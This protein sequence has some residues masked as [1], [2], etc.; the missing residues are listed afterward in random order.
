MNRALTP[1]VILS[2]AAFQAERRISRGAPQPPGAT[3][4]AFAKFPADS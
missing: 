1:D 4:R 3:S 2:E